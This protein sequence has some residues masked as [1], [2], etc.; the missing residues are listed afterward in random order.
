MCSIQLSIP[1]D[2]LKYSYVVA[3]VA[4]LR[5]VFRILENH[6]DLVAVASDYPKV[7]CF[8]LV[9]R[10]MHHL[11]HYVHLVSIHGSQIYNAS[12]DIA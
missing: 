9:L 6:I 5:L 4:L 10:T 7:S 1:C 12:C 11:S 2:P 8:L 3:Y